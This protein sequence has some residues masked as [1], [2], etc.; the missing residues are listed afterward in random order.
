MR[1]IK[2]YLA[3]VLTLVLTLSS[4]TPLYA[5]ENSDSPKEI[6]ENLLVVSDTEQYQATMKDVTT[7]SHA[8]IYEVVENGV[9]YRMIIDN[10]HNQVVINGIPYLYQQFEKALEIQTTA[11][12]NNQYPNLSEEYALVNIMKR[13]PVYRCTICGLSPVAAPSTGYT[14]NYRYVG[15]RNAAIE[16][17]FT[18]AAYAAAAKKLGIPA[19][20]VKDL[21]NKLKALGYIKY[22]TVN[23]HYS[24]YQC[25]HKRCPKAYKDKKVFKETGDTYYVTY[26]A[27]N[28]Y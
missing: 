26:Y 15:T 17:A 21:F 12:K 18:T 13:F 14:E 25:G 22:G 20:Q 4:F 7:D 3:S 24:L 16:L 23:I 8:S 10:F 6:I 27:Y 11:L 28:P 5:K 1:K 9:S 19:Y 2:I